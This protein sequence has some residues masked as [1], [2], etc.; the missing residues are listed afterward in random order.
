[1][2]TVMVVCTVYLQGLMVIGAQMISQVVELEASCQFSWT[3]LVDLPQRS[4]LHQVEVML[5]QKT[6]SKTQKL[7]SEV[8]KAWFDINGTECMSKSQAVYIY[9]RTRWRRYAR[10]RTTDFPD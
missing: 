10:Q 1:M 2:Y 9:T 3:W 5:V 6:Q 4:S 7:Y 8:F